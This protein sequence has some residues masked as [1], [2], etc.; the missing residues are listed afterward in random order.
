MSRQDKLKELILRLHDDEDPEQIKQEFNEHFGSVSAKEISE[1]EKALM[2]EGLEVEAIMKLCNV[3]AAVM[4]QSVQQIHTK[5]NEHEH[6]GHP[7]QVLKNENAAINMLLVQIEDRIKA[8]DLDALKKLAE[9]L[10]EIDKHYLRKEN[11]YFS[12]MEKYG[13]TAPPKVMWGVDD[14]IRDLIKTFRKNLDEGRIE[15]Y[16]EMAF[17]IREMIFK[18]EEIMIPMIMEDFTLNDWKAIEEESD[19]MGY[20]LIQPPVERWEPNRALTFVERYKKDQAKQVVSHET[21]NFK[22]GQL[23]YEQ[24]VKVLDHLPLEVTFIDDTDTFRYF[25]ES[26]H[27]YFPR[28]MSALGRHVL[29]CHPPKSQHIVTELLTDFR[30]GRKDKETLWFNKGDLFLVVT[31]V[32]LRDDTGKYIGTLEYVQEA[33]NIRQMEGDRRRAE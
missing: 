13:F 15:G 7:I 17:E 23:S 33:S 29:N 19:S 20:T 30:M 9:K 16:D 5:D 21:I 1:I 4:G 31:Y 6:Q 3:H 25:N 2:N 32:A 24:L 14:E 10:W 22:T 28:T 12:L 26:E 18:E 27:K 11:S 8:N